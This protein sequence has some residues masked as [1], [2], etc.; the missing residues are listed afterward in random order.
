MPNMVK[1]GILMGLVYSFSTWLTTF[2][3]NDDLGTSIY[4]WVL[5]IDDIR[6]DPGPY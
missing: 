3:S 4:T 5:I 2:E 6:T 1:S